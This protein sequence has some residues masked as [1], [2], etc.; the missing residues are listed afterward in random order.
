MKVSEISA[1]YIDFDY[2]NKIGLHPQD[3]RKAM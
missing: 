3:L 2:D 1:T